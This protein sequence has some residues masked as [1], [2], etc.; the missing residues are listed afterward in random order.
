MKFLLLCYSHFRS[1][2][3]LITC[4]FWLCGLSSCSQ[5]DSAAHNE[6]KK[7]LQITDSLIIAGKGDSAIALLQKLRTG[8]PASDPLICTY[9]YLLSG[10]NFNSPALMNKYADSAMVFFAD[11]KTIEKYPNEYFQS[12]LTKGDACLKNKDYIGA[13]KYY[14][15]GQEILPA[16]ICDNGNLAS[17]IGVIYFAQKNYIMAARYQAKS[18][19]R[20][21]QCSDG[22]TAQKLFFLK[23]GALNNTGFSFQK[24][25]MPDSAIKYY[26]KDVALI[27]NTERTRQIDERYI[28]S[29]RLV[30][31]DNLGGINLQQGNLQLAKSYLDKSTALD[32]GNMDGAGIPP[33]LKLAELNLKTGNYADIAGLFS[34]SRILLTLYPDENIDSELKW[35][36]L[37]AQYLFKINE[38]AKAYHF[39]NTY[40]DLKEHEDKT[41]SDLYRLNIDS[42]LKSLQQ[43]QALVKLQEQDKIKRMYIVG[44]AIF[45]IFSVATILMISRILKRT[46]ES[47]ETVT[48]HN[49]E[50]QRAMDELERVNKNYIRIMRV[51]AHDLR[52]P[53]SGITGL[54]AMLMIEDEFSEDSKNMLRLIETT[55]LHS[56][57]MINELLKSGLADENEK[58]VKQRIDL[59]SLLY[60]SVELL[61]FKAR[62]KNQTI[63]F[64]HDNKPLM[65]EVNHE[66]IWR[67]INNIIVNAIK[68]SHEGGI[69]KVGISGKES[70]ILISIA[71][72]GIGISEEQK[73]IVFEM[74]TPAKKSG[75]NGEQPFGLGLSISKRIIELHGGRIWFESN[76]G[77]GT[78]FY[79]E[80]PG[81]D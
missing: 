33:L 54:A 1:T 32:K 22:I 79:V 10:H 27:D 68:F 56:M 20:L 11:Q 2:F 71:D 74:F 9:Y 5:T 13:L 29:A 52:N 66:K 12:V 16:G 18:Y 50:L 76:M 14:Y 67:V 28:N 75:T 53:L 59:N 4:L 46:K 17:K 44:F 58:L 19:S 49:K 48:K 57:E 34:K 24:A 80:L 78:I 30:V 41:Y 55:G 61:Q 64:E 31:Y 26:L 23:Q 38:P 25:G 8:I 69:I 7:Q 42:E 43:K 39:L 45:V 21:G 51:M 36:R 60:D 63:A 81:L 62:E 72:N 15:K 70:K 73:D 77:K 47:R 40:L 3:F 35:N 65:A 37:Y 6:I